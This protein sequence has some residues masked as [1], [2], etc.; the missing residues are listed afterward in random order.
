M[1]AWDEEEQRAKS[2]RPAFGLG[3]ALQLQDLQLQ[4]AGCVTVLHLVRVFDQSVM[5]H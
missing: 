2:T 1:C 3:A 4:L 5:S